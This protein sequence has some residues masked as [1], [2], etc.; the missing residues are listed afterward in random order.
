M[1]TIIEARMPSVVITNDSPVNFCH[2]TQSDGTTMTANAYTS[3][4]TLL[5]IRVEESFKKKS[6]DARHSIVKKA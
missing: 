5:L 1:P 3:A 6:A 4:P 2:A